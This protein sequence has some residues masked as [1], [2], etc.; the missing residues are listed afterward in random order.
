MKTYR[1]LA[2]SL[3][4]A[5]GITSLTACG[6]A[7][8][9]GGSLLPGA[10]ATPAPT[11]PP[12]DSAPP[13]PPGPSSQTIQTAPGAVI[14]KANQFTPPIGDTPTGGQGQAV[15]G[16]TCD[17]TMSN[18]YHVHFYLG[19]WVNGTQ[20]AIPAGL[21]MLNPQP[22]QNGF[23]DAASCFYHIHTHD[24]SGL[25]HVE[26]PSSAPITQSLY[27]LKNVFDEWGI[28]V[29]A[30]QFGPFSGPVRVFTSGQVYRGGAANQT[31]PATDLTFYGTDATSV[32]LYSYEVIDVEVGPTF[33]SSLP[34]VYF[35]ETH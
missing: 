3:A 4:L 24:A 13:P 33:P 26:D 32:P 6:G 12:T 22:A 19:L 35:Y 14:G 34:N 15:D 30:N 7:G 25:V 21:G 29:N 27:T 10:T 28:T 23:I 18:S 17:P 9:S 31:T 11:S 5:F 16:I 8:S 2:R 20:I 1:T